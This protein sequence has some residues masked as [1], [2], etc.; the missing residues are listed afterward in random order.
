MSI[1]NYLKVKD[2]FFRLILYNRSKALAVLLRIF[3]SLCWLLGTSVHK[4][5]GLRQYN[6]PH[7]PFCLYEKMHVSGNSRTGKL[8]FIRHTCTYFS[9][10]QRDNIFSSS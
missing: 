5:E 4:I 6:G 9:A 10:K 7:L 8:I 2:L 1:I 3:L